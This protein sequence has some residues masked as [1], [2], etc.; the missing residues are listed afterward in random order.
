[1]KF[2]ACIN[3]FKMETPG[4]G[5][6]IADDPVRDYSGYMYKEQDFDAH[7]QVYVGV[8]MKSL[9]PPHSNYSRR[10]NG[11]RSKQHRHYQLSQR[12]KRQLV[13]MTKHTDDSA[14]EDDGQHVTP[15]AE[16]VRFILGAINEKDENEKCSTTGKHDLFTEL[17]EFVTYEDGREEWKETARWFKYEEDVEEGGDRW[18]KPHVATLS[19]YSL[20][21]VR[22]CLMSGTVMLDLEANSLAQIADLV[23]EHL[24]SCNK[25]EES[26]RTKMRDTLLRQHRH[27]KPQGIRKGLSNIIGKSRSNSQ[28]TGSASNAR[29][30]S[31]LSLPT[32][33]KTKDNGV[34]ATFPSGKKPGAERLLPYQKTA[35]SRSE[36]VP[37][38]LVYQERNENS[39]DV[40]DKLSGFMKKLP[41]QSE[42]SNV[43]VGEVDFLVKPITAFIRLQ[44]GVILGDLTEIAIPT[45]FLFIMMGPAISPGRYHEIGRS[46]STLMADEIFHDVAYMAKKR[47]DLIAGFD[48]FLE[49][50]TV[51]PPGEWDPSIRIEPPPETPTSDNKWPNGFEGR[52][53][54]DN[55]SL[56]GLKTGNSSD[57]NDEED[58]LTA[59]YFLRNKNIFGGLQQDFCTWKERVGDLQDTCNLQC[60]STVLFV[61]FITLAM[62]LVYGELYK[63]AT[64]NEIGTREQLLA[65]SINGIILAFFGGQPLVM[66]GLSLPL[67]AFDGVIYQLS[68]QFQLDFLPFRMWIGMWTTVFLILFLAFSISVYIRYLTRFTLEI[69]VVLIGFCAVCKSFMFLF[70]IK[71]HHPVLSPCFQQQGCLC[72]RYVE[73]TM[74]STHHIAA[75]TLTNSSNIHVNVSEVITRKSVECLNVTFN[76]C[77]VNNGVLFGKECDNGVFFLSLLITLCTLLLASFLAYLKLTGFFPRSFRRLV[78]DFATLSTVFLMSWFGFCYKNEVNISFLDIPTSYSPSESSRRSW[79]VQTL[80]SNEVWVILVALLPAVILTLMLFLEHGM[81]T[82]IA[83]RKENKLKKPYGYHLDLFTQV[84][85]L[86]LSSV[87]GLPFTVGS[88]FL[89]VNHIQG[90]HVDCAEYQR[91]KI[92]GVREQRFTALLASVLLL[93]SPLLQPILKCIPDA[94][95]LGIMFYAGFRM[96]HKVQF[97]D[98]LRLMLMPPRNQPDVIYLRQIPTIV[99]HLFTLVQLLCLGFLCAIRLTYASVIFPL[100]VIVVVLVRVLLSRLFNSH[101]LVLLD[102]AFPA[103]FWKKSIMMAEKRLLQDIEKA[104]VGDTDTDEA[105]SD[106]DVIDFGNFHSHEISISE[107]LVKMPVWKN[108][109]REDSSPMSSMKNS[110]RPNDCNRKRRR[111]HIRKKKDRSLPEAENSTENSSDKVKLEEVSMLPAPWDLPYQSPPRADFKF[112]T[113]ADCEVNFDPACSRTESKSATTESETNKSDGL[114]S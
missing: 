72:L 29:K 26:A 42:A 80:G 90:L 78:G 37:G 60:V 6:T 16:R 33:D 31:T 68:E 27:Q 47:D 30:T 21:E 36:S 93:M 79:M 106:E 9:Q 65:L 98:R 3:Y 49:K 85:G 24:I 76:E 10:P 107:E 57:N 108:L 89:T 71:A 52:K 99:A 19:L 63:A 59:R 53:S 66:V 94:V 35:F 56:T 23:L 109:T 45:K 7:R 28:Q 2:I 43:L 100:A 87:L 104:V 75:S 84:L 4:I 82:L 5:L 18:S 25:L 74:N 1:M 62:I 112:L 40:S 77:E 32:S 17:E 111:K 13:V 88:A 55:H 110:P 101:H 69:F 44:K 103:S 8:T 48:D 113:I 70:A 54:N 102:E 22:N 39:E 34:Y 15:A 91:S 86:V 61:Y 51:L 81:T 11:T 114:I 73:E 64:E 67:I 92:K 14:S 97:V 105:K 12:R 46:I 83:N 95:L 96:F 38:H 50:V 58:G 41:A 20:F